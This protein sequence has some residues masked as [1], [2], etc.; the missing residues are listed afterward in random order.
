MVFF[1]H[2]GKLTAKTMKQ[3]KSL[4]TPRFIIT[5]IAL[6][7]YYYESGRLDPLLAY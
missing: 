4:T 3:I 1:A 2:N 5:T 7:I 6:T